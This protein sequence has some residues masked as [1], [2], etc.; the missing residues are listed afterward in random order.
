ML[1][2]L[3]V[4]DDSQPH[5]DKG[6]FAVRGGVWHLMIML[7]GI[8]AVW[9]ACATGCDDKKSVTLESVEVYRQT[10]RINSLV[11]APDGNHLCVA[12]EHQGG[13]PATIAVLD[14]EGMRVTRR[15][16]LDAGPFPNHMAFIESGKL[17]VTCGDQFLK[18][19]DTS[20]W[21]QI[22][23]V[24]AHKV[25]ALSAQIK[26]NLIST[27]GGVFDRSLIVWNKDLT[28]LSQI[29]DAHDTG[30]HGL[31]YSPDGRRLVSVGDLGGICLW[32][33]ATLQRLAHWRNPRPLGYGCVAFLPT[34]DKFVL[35]GGDSAID[36]WD[37]AGHVVARLGPISPETCS[38]S[39]SADGRFLAACAMGGTWHS[40]RFGLWELPDGRLVT[41]HNPHY[42]SDDPRDLGETTLQCVALSPKDNVLATG[43]W[44]GTVRFTRLP[45]TQT[46]RP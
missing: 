17:F 13:L 8:L 15:T 16:K 44:A 28:R 37:L 11:F 39:V 1:A 12:N 32:D 18:I 42:K 2:A 10:G 24:Q 3:R 21:K 31:A 45:A 34:G 14:V 20:T 36:V 9:L 22:R 29:S 23:S 30:V 46:P 5:T 26:G 19:W 40:P 35:G 6:S 27:G 4:F 25:S 41:S 43:D 7:C 33:G 38:I